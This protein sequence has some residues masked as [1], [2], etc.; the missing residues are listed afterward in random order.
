V[1]AV[2][3]AKPAGNEIVIGG[4][5]QYREYI[6]QLYN[7][8]IGK[9]IRESNNDVKS[10][11][12]GINRFAD[13][14]LEADQIESAYDTYQKALTFSNQG[15]K[16]KINNPETCY[17]SG[18]IAW[19]AYNHNLGDKTEWE[20]K[21]TA[22]IK[23][24]ELAVSADNHYNIWAWGNYIFYLKS[25]NRTSDARKFVERVIR[26]NSSLFSS[27]D[28]RKQAALLRRLVKQGPR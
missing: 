25:T 26:E 11:A 18:N 21:F 1:L 3:Q 12:F 16:E 20:P 15:S 13:A 7:L 19:I 5:D 8:Q 23:V 2:Q 28:G 6:E 24:C 9:F 22:A 14:L 4:G 10:V 17:A 27:D